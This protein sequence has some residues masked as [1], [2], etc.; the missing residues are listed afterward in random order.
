[1]EKG[2][3]PELRPCLLNLFGLGKLRFSASLASLVALGLFVAVTHVV[4]TVGAWLF[5][6]AIAALSA[7]D[8]MRHREAAMADLR[9][10]VL[11]EFVGMFLC[12]LI[13]DST[14]MS[15][16][17][18]AFVL[19]RVI[20]VLKPPPFGY[21]DRNLKGIYAYMWDDVAIG[22]VIGILLRLVL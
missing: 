13:M 9:E 5:L 2:S 16:L 3:V 18:L 8:T 4:G 22:A 10:I 14:G 17:M 20:D 15:E 19:F 21:L 1:M 12:L 6:L 11:D 7:V